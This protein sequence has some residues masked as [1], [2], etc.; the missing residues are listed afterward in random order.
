MQHLSHH[1]HTVKAPTAHQEQFGAQCLAQ[2][3]LNM[4]LGEPG[5]G[6]SDL[7]ITRRPALPPELQPDK[8]K[9]F[10]GCSLCV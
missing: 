7:K 2:G 9:V 6:T 4:Q 1:I 10:S 8:Y 5:I 3:H